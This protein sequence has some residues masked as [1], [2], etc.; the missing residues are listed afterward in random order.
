MGKKKAPQYDFPRSVSASSLSTFKA[1]ARKSEYYTF[2]RWVPREKSIHLHA[3]AA[4]ASAIEAARR[5]FYVDSMNAEQSIIA[6]VRTLWFEYGDFEC[7]PESNKSCMNL[8]HAFIGY[9]D[10][11]P[12]GLDPITPLV[13]AS[14]TAIEFDFTADL[15]ITHPTS[16]DPILYTGRADMLGQFQSSLWNVDEKTTS[17]IGPAWARKWSMRSQFLGTIWAAAQY[18][19][20][21]QGT[22]VRGIAV[23]KNQNKTAEHLAPANPHMVE[24]WYVSTLATVQLMIRA[25]ERNEFPYNFDDACIAYNST[26]EYMPL[27]Q[28]QDYKKWL[29]Y[30]S[31]R[32]R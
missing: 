32:T 9:F 28:A 31:Q 15:L 10:T 20:K 8:T 14:G 11:W 4:F 21:L 3:G 29:M 6:G 22:I 25:W 18:G 5:S 23:L 7:P 2:M 27:C 12:L 24:R 1:C 17:G 30:F 19:H 13:L 16:G 26:C